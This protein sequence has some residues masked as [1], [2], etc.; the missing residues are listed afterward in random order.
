LRESTQI[1]E[2]ESNS[3]AFIILKAAQLEKQGIQKLQK[4]THFVH[5]NR[6]LNAFISESFAVLKVEKHIDFVHR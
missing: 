4:V 5:P 3:C 6:Q 1:H 2:Y